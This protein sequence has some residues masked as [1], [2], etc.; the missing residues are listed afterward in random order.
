MLNI[1]GKTIRGIVLEIEQ[2]RAHRYIVFAS[3]MPVDEASTILKA[4]RKANAFVGEHVFDVDAA[5]AH[6]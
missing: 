4:K 6:H 3:G 1:A 5:H 2:A